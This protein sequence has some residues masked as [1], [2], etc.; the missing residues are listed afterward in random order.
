MFS[1]RAWGGIIL[2]ND[3]FYIELGISISP[4]VFH[5][6][7]LSQ[8][9]KRSSVKKDQIHLE[10]T[11]LNQ[12]TSVYL[13]WDFSEPLIVYTWVPRQSG[14]KREDAASAS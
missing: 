4:L 14:K 9:A 11:G 8:D 2:D 13:L 12:V 3:E 1:H 7:S 10:S 5:N 6:T